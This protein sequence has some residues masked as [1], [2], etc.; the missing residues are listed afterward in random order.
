MRSCGHPWCLWPAPKHGSSSAILSKTS[1]PQ[2][3]GVDMST[4]GSERRPFASIPKWVVAAALVL[5]VSVPSLLV[6]APCTPSM[7]LTTVEVN[8]PIVRAW[9]YLNAGTSYE[10]ETKNLSPYSDTVMRIF[11]YQSGAQYY[12]S[13]E[14]VAVDDDGDTYSKRAR[15]LAPTSSASA[16]SRALET[17][18]WEPRTSMRRLVTCMW[19]G[20]TQV[21]GSGSAECPTAACGARRHR[22]SREGGGVGTRIVGSRLS[23]PCRRFCW[24]GSG[25]Q[26]AA[27]QVS[28]IPTIH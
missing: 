13:N 17:P 26:V 16:T 6:A 15:S 2:T 20:A 25:F 28:E 9:V 24:P 4:F 8:N 11:Q 22:P 5:L 7:A 19:F 27:H 12:H 18:L 23:C 3:R 1:K 14:E 10:F 21:T